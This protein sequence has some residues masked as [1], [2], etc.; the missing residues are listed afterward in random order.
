M[1]SHRRRLWWAALCLGLAAAV[2]TA[3][4]P[5]RTPGQAGIADKAADAATPSAQRVNRLGSEISQARMNQLNVL[6]PGTFKKAEEAYFN[7]RDALE[8]GSRTEVVDQEVL[9]SRAYLKKAEAS[10]D[11]ART[12]LADVLKAREMARSAGAAAFEKPY[13]RVEDDFL[14]L[15]RAVER[16]NLPAAEKGRE[17]VIA[18]YQALEIRA[19]KEATIGD[20][21]RLIAEAEA[22]GAEKRCPRTYH[23]ATEQLQATDAFISANPHAKEKMHAM[24]QAALFQANRLVAVTEA[25]SRLKA[26]DLEAVALLMESHLHAIASRLGAQD[27]RDHDAQTQLDNILGA[28]DALKN[29][30]DFLSQ[31]NQQ[32]LAE[33][34]A[35]KSDYQA[36]IDA[37]N[38]QLA[39]LAGRSREDQMAKERMARERMAAEQRLAAERKFNQRYTAVRDYFESDEA[40]VY[41]QENQLVIRLKAMRFPVGKSVI[42]PENYALLSKVQKAIR[43]FDDPRVIVEGHTDATGSVEVNTLLSQQRAD[44]V[45]AYLI[46]NQ[47]LAPGSISA[48]GY[49]SERPL[50]SNATAAGRAINRRIDIVILPQTKPI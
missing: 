26:M 32:L 4:A 8:N 3:C 40:E 19:I 22:M 2:T 18:G 29:D 35:L 10:A 50:A 42:L 9:A 23:Q 1:K 13:R 41:K 15:T 17:P 34:E 48:V 6:S 11:T 24:A 20:V 7:A 37:L 16:D 49:G 25:C 43:T 27:L 47:T 39:T 33:M 28:V 12:L 31:K 36:R 46:A 5:S 21:R 44:A 30:R 45:R 14:D 38:V